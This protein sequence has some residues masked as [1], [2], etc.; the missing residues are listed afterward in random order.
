MATDRSRGNQSAGIS[1]ISTSVENCEAT[2]NENEKKGLS[3]NALFG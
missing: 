1:K 2:K 3:V